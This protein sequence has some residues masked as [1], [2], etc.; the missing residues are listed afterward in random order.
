MVRSQVVKGRT[1]GT[2]SPNRT[3]GRGGDLKFGDLLF[4]VLRLLKNSGTSV[5]PTEEG[6]RGN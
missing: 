4:L 6:K 3:G 2:D 5:E 1:I